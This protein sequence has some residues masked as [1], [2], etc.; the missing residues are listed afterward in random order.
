MAGFSLGL[1]Q[2]FSHLESFSMNNFG[3]SVGLSLENFDI[4]LLYNFGIK[5]IKTLSKK[6]TQI[7][8]E[9]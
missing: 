6:T 8:K 2:Q 9:M 7:G 1:N 5:N 3:V 4:G